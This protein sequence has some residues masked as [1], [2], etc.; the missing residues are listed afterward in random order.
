MNV[1]HGI[2]TIAEIREIAEICHLCLYLNPDPTYLPKILAQ[3]QLLNIYC[4]MEGNTKWNEL[5]HATPKTYIAQPF[6]MQANIIFGTF[7]HTQNKLE[8]LWRRHL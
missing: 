6:N 4:N 2:S 5:S 1:N 3:C 7:L 8:K